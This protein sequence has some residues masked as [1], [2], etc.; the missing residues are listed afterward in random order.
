MGLPRLVPEGGLTV[1]SYTIPRDPE[2]W[3]DDVEAFR[4]KRRFEQ[5]QAEVQETFDPFSYGPRSVK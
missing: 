3:G 2:I 5:D 4:P 1:P